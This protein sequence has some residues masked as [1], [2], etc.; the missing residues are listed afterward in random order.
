[1]EQWMNRVMA[2]FLISG[3]AA[4]PAFSDDVKDLK[5]GKPEERAAAA[6][7]LGQLKQY[8]AIPDLAL[9]LK[10]KDQFVR[11]NSAAALWLMADQA[12]QAKGALVEA[13]NDSYARVTV[14]AAGALWGMET[15]ATE[16]LPALEKVISG[17]S[18]PSDGVAAAN[19]AITPGK[20]PREM[21][22][23]LLRGLTDVNPEA[24]V[25]VITGLA[26]HKERSLEYVPVLLKGLLDKDRTVR[27]A[28]ATLLG[29]RDYATSEV[30]EALQR[31]S[32][33]KDQYVRAAATTA[34]TA[35]GTGA[36]DA[37]ADEITL[38]LLTNIKDSKSF[39][40]ASAAES[41]GKTKNATPEIIGALRACI[42]DGS[43]DVRSAAVDAL[44][45]IGKAAQEAVPDLLLLSNSSSED[46]LM[47]AFAQRAIESITRK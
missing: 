37:G 35:L 28:A 47:R 12:A 4:L 46:Q 44:G 3:L 26:E 24:R 14:N 29:N 30:R 42:K 22:P 40:R 1:M 2:A 21:V 38:I 18:S 19:L 32:A 34:L 15:P 41:L 20:D 45:T 33:D 23:A 17:R 8:S 25:E 10:D 5:R 36:A 16:L 6:W 43:R 31:T 9:A 27:M 7:N 13:L 39:V 11:S